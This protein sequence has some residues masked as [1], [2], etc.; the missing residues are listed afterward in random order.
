MYIQRVE[1][2]ENVPCKFE[3][4]SDY[5]NWDDRERL[6][7]LR[8]SLEGPAGQVLW[9]AGQQSSVDDV[10]TLLKNR[11]G[12]LNEEERYRSELNRPFVVGAANH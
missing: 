11:L 1:V 7:H 10:I 5:Y 6:Y 8:D 4:C 2:P 9:N 3:N 12:S